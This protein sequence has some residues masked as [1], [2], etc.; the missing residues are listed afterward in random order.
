MT[1]DSSHPPAPSGETDLTQYADEQLF[2]DAFGTLTDHA[3]RKAALGDE[4]RFAL[5]YYLFKRGEVARKEITAEIDDPDLDLT[6]HLDA[7]ITGGLVA[8]TGAPEESD[9]HQTI[10]RITHIGQQQIE[11]DIQNITGSAP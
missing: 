3:S 7:L 8:R 5:L 10:Y 11:A 6:H 1:S 2:S 9:G 4:L